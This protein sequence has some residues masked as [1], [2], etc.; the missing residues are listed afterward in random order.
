LFTPRSDTRDA[1]ITA[2]RSAA[3]SPPQSCWGSLSV[4]NKWR[5]KQ[6]WV[7]DG[8]EVPTLVKSKQRKGGRFTRNCATNCPGEGASAIHL[9]HRTLADL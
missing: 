5:R 7:S 6:H 3:A 1:D 2:S 9:A 4:A 8:F